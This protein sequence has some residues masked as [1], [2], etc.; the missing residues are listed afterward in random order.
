[1]FVSHLLSQSTVD[2]VWNTEKRSAQVSAGSLLKN[3]DVIQVSGATSAEGFRVPTRFLK[4]KTALAS[5]F[6]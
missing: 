1:M 3:D 6:T 5:S 2:C 4:T